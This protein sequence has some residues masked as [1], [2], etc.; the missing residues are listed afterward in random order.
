MD[1]GRCDAHDTLN[2]H[3]ESEKLTTR[4]ILWVK[5]LKYSELSDK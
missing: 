4:L 1:R 3:V 2:V 5:Y